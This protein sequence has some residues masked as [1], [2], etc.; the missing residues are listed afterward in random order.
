[1]LK[2]VYPKIVILSKRHKLLFYSHEKRKKRKDVQKEKEECNVC[3]VCMKGEKK[4]IIVII[5][6]I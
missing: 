2:L 3:Y 6:Y 4:E 1:M 5:M